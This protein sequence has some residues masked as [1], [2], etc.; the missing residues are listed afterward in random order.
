MG[1]G[2]VAC[3]KLQRSSHPVGAWAEG[4]EA[5]GLKRGRGV[6]GWASVYYPR[7]LSVSAGYCS[8]DSDDKHGNLWRWAGR[9]ERGELTGRRGG[10]ADFPGV[11]FPL[12][13]VSSIM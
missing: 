6:G 9:A 1:S 8:W 10:E 12:W 2:P 7:G 3:C 11:I 4:G 5:E 13:P